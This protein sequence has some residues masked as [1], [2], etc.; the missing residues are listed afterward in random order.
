ML[1]AL[2]A[3]ES[4]PVPTY[5]RLQLKYIELRIA[6]T[7]ETTAAFAALILLFTTE[8]M[9]AKVEVVA[10]LTAAQPDVNPERTLPIAAVT[11]LFVWF[12]PL[13]TE[14]TRPAIPLFAA[15]ARPDIPLFTELFRAESAELTELFIWAM[16]VFTCV[17]VC[18]TACAEDARPDA[19]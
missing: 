12:I 8:M 6:W 14:L 18:V 2:I 7:A 1:T 13:L 11:A 15:A 19:P 3:D 16:A 17:A 10:L 9:E 5:G 4:A